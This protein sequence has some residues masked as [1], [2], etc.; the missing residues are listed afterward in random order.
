MDG[1]WVVVAVG[2][3]VS[4][5]G[6]REVMADAELVKSELLVVAVRDSKGWSLVVVV[7]TVAVSGCVSAATVLSAVVV[8]GSVV[9]AN[10]I[11]VV[12]GVAVEGVVSIGVVGGAVIRLFRFRLLKNATRA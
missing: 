9:S 3:R 2:S 5:S 4:F 8:V 1:T 11:T 7:D 10:G 6:E 12:V